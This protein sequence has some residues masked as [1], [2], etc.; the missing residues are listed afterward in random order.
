M[1]SLCLCFICANDFPLLLLPLPRVL[2]PPAPRPPRAQ[3]PRS[4][5]EPSGA[6]ASPLLQLLERLPRGDVGVAPTMTCAPPAR[7]PRVDRPRALAASSARP[8][9][10]QG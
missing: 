10:R 7:H 3:L 2:S 9:Q 4:A 6:T 5:L 1:F 8:R